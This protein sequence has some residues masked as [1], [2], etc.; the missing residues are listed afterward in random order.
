MRM[1]PQLAEDSR[2]GSNGEFFACVAGD[3]H[4]GKNALYELAPELP[5]RRSDQSKKSWRPL[6]SL[7]DPPA[8]KYAAELVL[9]IYLA[10]PERD[11]PLA[12]QR[13]NDEGDQCGPAF[14][15]TTPY[16]LGRQHAQQIRRRGEAG[17]PGI[18]D[19]GEADVFKN[20]HP[21]HLSSELP[22][23]QSE[24]PRPVGT[25]IREPLRL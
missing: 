8:E 18:C 14:A 9:C 17:Q 1:I 7:A 10:G 21:A 2:Q 5:R 13:V 12:T 23:E 11:R 6:V 22:R 19:L 15:Q 25:M 3:P 20:V 24:R 16:L 4:A